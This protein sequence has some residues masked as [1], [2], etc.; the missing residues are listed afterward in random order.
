[1]EKVEL[2]PV[3]LMQALNSNKSKVYYWISS[4]K[5][6]TV[7]RLEGQKV[8]ISREDLERLKKSNNYENF[9]NFETVSE[10]PNN[11]EKFLR[12]QA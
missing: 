12:M 10:N 7:E 4:G 1:M 9:E 11:F 8:V 5:F 2:T 3:E 6:E